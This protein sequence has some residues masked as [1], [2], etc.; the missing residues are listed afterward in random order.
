MHKRYPRLPGIDKQPTL[1]DWANIRK[2]NPRW[3]NP[4]RLDLILYYRNPTGF[5]L[6]C[7]AW[8][9]VAIYTIVPVTE[10]S[11][12]VI[13]MTVILVTM[14]ECYVLCPLLLTFHYMK[15]SIMA[16]FI[17]QHHIA[18][19]ADKSKVERISR[20][21]LKYQHSSDIILSWIICIIMVGVLVVDVSLG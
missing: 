17:L 5:S 18:W 8:T 9:I 6:D 3:L 13:L 4:F 19:Q 11:P 14:I 20:S 7:V 10:I 12:L 1:E 16:Q 2:F 21:S 15:M